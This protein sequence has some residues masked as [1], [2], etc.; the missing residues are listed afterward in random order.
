M[1]ILFLGALFSSGI[2]FMLLLGHLIKLRLTKSYP[3]TNQFSVAVIVPC[4]GDN[5]PSFGENLVSIIC[6]KYAGGAAQFIFSVESSTDSALPVLCRLK[7]Q[8]D[9][10][11]ICIAGLAQKSSQKNLNILKGMELAAEADI[12]LFADADIQPHPTWLQEMMA[13]FCDSQVDVVTGCFRRVPATAN[14]RLGNY[15]AGLFGAG[16]VTGMTD[17]RIGGLWGGS[18]AIRQTTVGNLNLRDRLA[19]EIVD[20]VAIMHAVHQHKVERR[21]V[22]SCTLKSYCE[23]STPASIEWLVRQLQFSQ[24]YFKKLYFFYY[25]FGLPYTFSILAAPLAFTYGLV[26]GSELI[27][28]ATVSFWLSVAV[29]GLL[30]HQSVPINPASVSSQDA[31]YQIIPWLL[32]TPLAFVVG[33]LALLKTLWRVRSGIL[34]MYWRSIE[35]RV[36]VKTGKVLE[37]IR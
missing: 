5:D 18:L 2:I 4:K 22:A 10:V 33:T 13:P 21:Y 7:Q 27:I 30:L 16:I 9:H 34:T 6:Q 29:V 25:V 32:V 26:S 3:A 24:I 14:F 19:S 17:D 1:I 23:M 8:F 31:N 20:D 35:Y 28:T 15:L 12:L 11:Q 36:D 37:I